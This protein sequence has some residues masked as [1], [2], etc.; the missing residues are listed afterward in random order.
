MLKRWIIENFKS[1]HGKA[2]FGLSPITVLAGANSSGKS[3]VI[4]GIL[5]A[6]QTVQH[7]ATQRSVAL[8]GP[9]L[10]L[11]RFDDISQC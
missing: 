10:R 9:I 3:T 6:K 7:G 1:F 5:L 2:E 8:N 4:Q 11:G